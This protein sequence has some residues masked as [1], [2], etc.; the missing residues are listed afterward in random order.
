MLVVLVV[1]RVGGGSDGDG[2]WW[3]WEQLVMVVVVRFLVCYKSL[4]RSISWPDFLTASCDHL[5]SLC[6]SFRSQ[7]D[8]VLNIFFLS[9]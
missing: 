9:S 7:D 1:V 6:V 3:W 5:L 8:F 4:Q 2:Q